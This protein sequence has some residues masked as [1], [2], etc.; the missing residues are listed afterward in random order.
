VNGWRA[1]DTGILD[2]LSMTCTVVHDE[3]TE[4]LDVGAFSMRGAQR[5]II[6]YLIS[7]GY[8]PL[9]RWEIQ[10][11]DA[12][13]GSIDA[14]RNF[15]VKKRVRSM[16]QDGLAATVAMHENDPERLHG[17]GRDLTSE[18]GIAKERQ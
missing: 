17:V 4:I 9:C 13:R 1:S 15:K 8:E 14:V 2:Q 12:E 18:L 10:R 16:M 5:E 11:F 3:S 7:Q 6:G